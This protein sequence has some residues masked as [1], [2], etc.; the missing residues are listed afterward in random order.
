[1]LATFPRGDEAR[2]RSVPPLIFPILKL[3]QTPSLWMFVKWNWHRKVS[4]FCCGSELST[5]LGVRIALH[6]EKCLESVSR[7]CVMTV[8]AFPV[9][10]CHKIWHSTYEE[11]VLQL[12]C[13]E[14]G[15]APL[16][17]KSS[18]LPRKCIRIEKI[19]L[20]YFTNINFDCC[21]EVQIFIFMTSSF[22]H[23][24]CEKIRLPQ[25]LYIYRYLC[26]YKRMQWRYGSLWIFV[27]QRWI[28]VL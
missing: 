11:C 26:W 9:D 17:T 7:R 25:Y 8:L 1:M 28:V 27:V 22:A 3:Y 20:Q 23:G 2:K 6:L 18:S 19:L 14:W 13:L 4:L 24:I 10:A 12:P 21:V 5:F 15:F 16:Q